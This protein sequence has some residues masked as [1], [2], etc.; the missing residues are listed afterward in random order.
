MVHVRL[1]RAADEAALASLDSA[2]WSSQS[3]FP[4]VIQPADGQP[5]GFFSAD[6]PPE[7]HLV[8]E[9]DDQ[10]VG[11]VR[12]KPPTPLRENEHVL[13]VSGIAVDPAARRRGVAAALLL[14]AE[15][16]ARARN[17]RKITLRVFGSNQPAIRVYRR[18]GYE[19]EGI[20]REEFFI[21]GAYVDDILM[22]KH[23]RPD[24]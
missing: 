9:A 24:G 17:A 13:Q 21:D 14:A 22:A 3:G 18:L 20:L 4:S 7:K 11:Y 1:A 6:N 19:T 15:Q 12:L 8:A 10:I 16:H 23:L 5:A 2:A